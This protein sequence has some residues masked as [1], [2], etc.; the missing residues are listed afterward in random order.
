MCAASALDSHGLSKECSSLG[1]AFAR[2]TAAVSSSNITLQSYL[3]FVAA[4]VATIGYA[5]VGVFA[6]ARYGLSTEGDVLVNKWLPGRWDGA[7]DGLVAIYLSLSMVSPCVPAPH[8]SLANAGSCR[9]SCQWH[10]HV[11]YT[12]RWRQ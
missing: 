3:P 10:E 1:G 8:L 6:A 12:S 2:L 7:L 9:A 11:Y 4:V 5:T